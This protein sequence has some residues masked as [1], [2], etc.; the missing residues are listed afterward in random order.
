VN[1]DVQAL[2]KIAYDEIKADVPVT[3]MKYRAN[4]RRQLAGKKR[5]I[6]TAPV[7]TTTLEKLSEKAEAAAAKQEAEN[8]KLD[9]SNSSVV[10]FGSPSYAVYESKQQV[11]LSIVRF[12]Q[13]DTQIIVGFATSDGTALAGEDY[14]HTRGNVLFAPGEVEKKI[15][16]LLIDDTEYEPDEFFCVSLKE[17]KTGKKGVDSSKLGNMEL[18][19]VSVA[20]VT[21]LND[22][23]PGTFG[24]SA[25][26]YS[27]Q[28]SSK[29]MEVI[30]ERKNGSDGEVKVA[31]TTVDGTACAGQDFVAT[32]GTLVFKHMETQKSII[33]PLIEDD[34]YEKEETFKIE[35]SLPGSPD[36]GAKY[37]QYRNAI[38]TIMGD[39][40]Y[41]KVIDQVAKI[42][43]DIDQNMDIETTSWADQF[44]EAMNIEGD[45]DDPSTADYVMHFLTFGWKVLFATVPP[46]SYGGGWVCFFV[47]LAYIGVITGFVADIASIF[48]CLIGMKDTIT[49]ITF[50]ALGTSLP[51]TFASKTAAVNDKTAD[52][53]IG[54]VT[55]SNSVNVFL[56]LGLPWL[57][58]TV[59]HSASGYAPEI[60][61][62][63]VKTTMPKG[64]YAVAAGSLGFSVVLFCC[65]G[66]VCLGTIY[67]RQLSGIGA[68]GGPSG[69]KNAT[70]MLFVGLWF[71]YV[72]VSW[73]EVEGMITNPFK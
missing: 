58:A 55:G 35:L 41:A 53:S 43:A 52:A 30:V 59:V 27:A 3:A 73:L 22:D 48:G 45:E 5:V 9:G 23:E 50:V 33:I 15:S 28:E 14:H 10:Q 56:G 26:S 67:A 34:A 21:I 6:Q 16:V 4:A 13:T 66:I 39:E 1:D 57:I 31:Y 54:N 42:V 44:S 19:P 64:S 40:D 20:N 25:A 11:E 24:F 69:P 47:A 38:L 72:A 62:D 12:G 51:D 17:P 63:G 29:K 2:A 49:A 7:D 8:T 36:N 68:L 70:G 65:C 37:G 18:G 32:E 71:V 46:T 60:E 61:L